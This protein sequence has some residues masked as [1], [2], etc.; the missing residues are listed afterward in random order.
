M[1]ALGTGRTRTGP[2]AVLQMPRVRAYGRSSVDDYDLN[3]HITGKVLPDTAVVEVL[4]GL[5]YDDELAVSWTYRLV[6]RKPASEQPLLKAVD[7]ANVPKA[8]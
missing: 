3:R 4:E 6:A 1:I 5:S 7:S 2:L 8:A